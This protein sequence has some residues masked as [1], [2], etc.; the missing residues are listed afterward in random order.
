MTK[1]DDES[2]LVAKEIYGLREAWAIRSGLT[3]MPYVHCDP[4]TVNDR[5][6]LFADKA[7]AERFC[8]GQP[9]E[10]RLSVLPLETV[11]VKG[12]QGG[13]VS[14]VRGFLAQLPT[15]DVDVVFYTPQNGEGRECYVEDILPPGFS[16]K[17]MGNKMYN[18]LL[19]LTG[20]FFCQEARLPREAQD[21]EELR[22][23][24]EEFSANLVKSTLFLALLPPEKPQPGQTQVPLSQCRFPV[25][26]NKKGEAFMPVFTDITELQK[27]SAGQPLAAMRV[28]FTRLHNYF[29]ENAKCYLLNPMGISLPLMREQLAPMAARF[30]LQLEPMEPGKK[31]SD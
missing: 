28:G 17:L 16:G 4:Q 22:L 8:A 21:P 11:P 27:Y 15:L 14:R 5:V 12:A 30:G 9:A 6:Y 24:E 23:A 10:Q 2:R 3:N 26:K 31:A 1:R 13:T 19:Q 20:I 18:P 29:L 25:A 7:Q